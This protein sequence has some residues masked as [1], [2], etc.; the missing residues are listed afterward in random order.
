[1]WRRQNQLSY[2]F[3]YNHIEASSS[4]KNIRKKWGRTAAHTYADTT[5]TA[6]RYLPF[7]VASKKRG[8]DN[9]LIRIFILYVSKN[10]CVSQSTSRPKNVLLKLLRTRLPVYLFLFS[11]GHRKVLVRA[12][13]IIIIRS[14]CPPRS[15]L[16]TILCLS[17]CV[18]SSLFHHDIIWSIGWVKFD[19]FPFLFDFQPKKK[20][21]SYCY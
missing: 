6:N 2:I 1:M 19:L 13:K 11:S 10:I 20:T 8:E 9:W 12:T 17:V 16:T 3:Y 4:R 14:P 21:S 15:T 7:L 18:P 5:S